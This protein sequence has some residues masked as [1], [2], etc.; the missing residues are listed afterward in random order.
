[1]GGGRD[2][3]GN[4]VYRVIIVD[5][6]RKYERIAPYKNIKAPQARAFSNSLFSNSSF[7]DDIDRITTKRGLEQYLR[8]CGK[9][10]SVN[11]RQKVPRA[12][13]MKNDLELV[14]RVVKTID[15]LEN[16]Y[17]FMKGFIKGFNN[18]E[19]GIA[20][21]DDDD[22]L[23]LNPGYW[24]EDNGHLYTSSTCTFHPPNMT[25]EAFIAHEF[26][27]AIH[28]YY[29]QKK[30]E[31]ERKKG[32]WQEFEYYQKIR[33]GSALGDVEAI[34]VKRLGVDVNTARRGISE[35]ATG[36]KIKQQTVFGTRTI[37]VDPTHESFAEAFADV[38][39]NKDNASDASK[40][41]V[42]AM[43]SEIG[44]LGG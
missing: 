5:G 2:S 16:R 11:G 21:I 36:M 7:S 33:D 39:A 25:P 28:N 32:M 12:F 4:P 30:L 17:P 42:E 8:Y 37:K 27:H 3:E 10:K 13:I 35:Y 34:A 1:M 18:T 19:L 14:K 38:Y 9:Y 26:G 20:Q 41:Y 44:K 22:Y 24:G 31:S 43:L 23:L 6:K 15:E 40:A 29:M